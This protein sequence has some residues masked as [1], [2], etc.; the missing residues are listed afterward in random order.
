MNIFTVNIVIKQE[1][2][3]TSSHKPILNKQLH[4]PRLGITIIT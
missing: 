3:L 4:Y 2:L 1:Q